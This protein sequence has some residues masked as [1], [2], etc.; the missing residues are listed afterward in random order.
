MTRSLTSASNIFRRELCPGSAAAEA[1]F[2]EEKDSPDSMEGTMLHEHDA[3]PD[4]DRAHLNPEQ[5]DVLAK[6]ARIDADIFAAV[7]ES[8]DAKGAPF[9]EGREQTL[10]LRKGFKQLYPGHCD[11][12]R[13]Y[14]EQKALVII[15]KKFGRNDVT[16]AES[17]L[18]LRSYAVMGAEQHGAERVAVAISQ[19]RRSREERLTLAEYRSDD[20]KAAKEHLIAVFYGAHNADGTPREDV[21]RVAGEEQCRYC[22][23]RLH[24]DTYRAKF[25]FLAEQPSDKDLFMARVRVMTPEQ[26]DKVFQA[27]K[28][29]KAVDDDLKDY[30]KELIEAGKLDNYELKPTG[31]MS[32]VTDV[33]LAARLLA[34]MGINM[35]TFLYAC[36]PALDKLADDYHALN[37]GMTAK[38]AKIAIRDALKDV[39]DIKPKAPSLK[40]IGEPKLSPPPA[41]QDALFA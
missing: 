17:N 23:A 41:I 4:L 26:V 11:L 20:L 5:H 25:E 30:V 40:R 13:W 37:P 8:I 10:N 28:L 1:Q 2:P 12:L 36:R 19:P 35:D 34:P 29:A 21:P 9:E 3:K 14:P 33:A 38:D 32:T 39:L 31:N 16:A 24:C 15:D 18:Q 6:A 7:E 27:V 22:K